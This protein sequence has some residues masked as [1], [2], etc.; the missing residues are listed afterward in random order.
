M[1]NFQRIQVTYFLDEFARIEAFKAGLF[2]FVHENAAKNW[3]R[4][5]ALGLRAHFW[6]TGVRVAC[7]C[8][9]FID[10]AM[11][12]SVPTHANGVPT[13]RVYPGLIGAEDAA[14]R[15]LDGLAA[16]KAV[17]TFPAPLYL[18]AAALSRAPLPF[19]DFL[20]RNTPIVSRAARGSAR[21]PGG[22]PCHLR[23]QPP[24]LPQRAA[25]D[26][27]GQARCDRDGLLPARHHHPAA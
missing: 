20:L 1:Y 3:A 23:A 8:P 4:A 26:P 6:S 14:R 9:G 13:L 22:G 10:T 18:V 27:G 2:D 25:E 16:D 11:T 12:R 17:V 7:L 21:R 5:W 24:Q 15:F 19:A